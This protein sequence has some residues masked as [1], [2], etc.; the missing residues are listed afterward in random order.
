MNGFHTNF[1]AKLY[2]RCD[3]PGL[4][5][6]HST[7]QLL[8]VMVILRNYSRQLCLLCVVS[9]LL[10][11]CVTLLGIEIL[12]SEYCKID[13]KLLWINWKVKQPQ[14]AHYR[15]KNLSFIQFI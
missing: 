2:S 7:K 1:F 11:I 9:V 10:K 12:F 14:S 8:S 6:Q 5:M 4:S 3:C 15:Y 13:L